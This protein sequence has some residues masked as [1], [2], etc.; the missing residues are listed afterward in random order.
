MR[1][2]P[3]KRPEVGR[4]M[5]VCKMFCSPNVWLGRETTLQNTL[6]AI[7]DSEFVTC[8]GLQKGGGGVNNSCSRCDPA[9]CGD[10]GRG[11][12]MFT[13]LGGAWPEEFRFSRMQRRDSQ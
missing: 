9:R 4:M 12:V 3:R 7:P 8:E 2:R 5:P 11:G 13:Y 10:A 1:A 6:R